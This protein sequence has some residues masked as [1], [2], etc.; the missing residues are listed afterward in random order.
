MVLGE[1]DE[2]VIEDMASDIDLR[3]FY[4]EKLKDKGID[5]SADVIINLALQYLLDEIRVDESNMDKV[6]KEC[7]VVQYLNLYG[8]AGADSEDKVLTLHDI[9]NNASG[10]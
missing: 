9:L 5:E 6:C 1:F 4:I 7:V 2:D 8:D 10:N 3:E